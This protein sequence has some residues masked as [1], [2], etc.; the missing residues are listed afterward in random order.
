MNWPLFPTNQTFALALLSGAVGLSRFIP[1][2]RGRPV[3]LSGSKRRLLELRERCLTS[4]P[5][6]SS[7]A[8]WFAT[9]SG[10]SAC[11]RY[12]RSG[13][14]DGKPTL[15][16]LHGAHASAVALLPLI[17]AVRA[18][19][20]VFALDLPG[21]GVSD[22]LRGT[23]VDGRTDAV[24]DALRWFVDAVVRVDEAPISVY[25]HSLG[26]YYALELARRYP[27]AVSDLVLACPAGLFSTLGTSGA[28]WALLFATSA[29]HRLLR[30]LRWFVVP[31][32]EACA[33]GPEARFRARLACSGYEGASMLAE[34]IRF[35][36]RNASWRRPSLEALSTVRART[37]LLFGERDG[38]IPAHQGDAL[39]RLSKG[40]LHCRSLREAPHC[41]HG[42]DRSVS[43]IARVI[44]DRESR[45][46]APSNIASIAEGASRLKR[47]GAHA[48]GASFDR[49]ISLARIVHVY[50]IMLDA[51]FDSDL[52][53]P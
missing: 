29:H 37:S 12:L 13:T 39:L 24:V 45:R 35:D 23:D 36:P 21:W 52:V 44:E 9:E 27:E 34:H 33:R 26:A 42:D 32:V 6:V 8:A 10:P 53:Q 49:R 16:L 20:R 19:H 51:R 11:L 17:D 5:D 43:E 50:E 48:L 18:T 30:A 3:G 25:A 1:F 2:R 47:N 31:L 7:G 41:V 14:G 28:Y 15:L 46:A 38:L 4:H 40:E 22:A